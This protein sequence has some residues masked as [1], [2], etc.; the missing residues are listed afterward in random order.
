MGKS[1]KSEQRKRSYKKKQI[2]IIELK[3]TVMC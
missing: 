2:E 1:R 3:N